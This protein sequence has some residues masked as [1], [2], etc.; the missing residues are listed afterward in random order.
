MSYVLHNETFARF[1]LNRGEF[2]MGSSKDRLTETFSRMLAT[3]PFQQI[4]IEDVARE[5]GVSRSTFYRHFSDKFELMNWVFKGRVDALA[6]NNPHVSDCKHFFI[7]YSRFLYQNKDYF[8]N[9]IKYKGQ[10][11]LKDL[12][13]TDGIKLYSN[14]IATALAGNEMPKQV[15]F[16]IEVFVSGSIHITMQWLEN[17]LKETP[18]ELAE[19]TFNCMP[20]PMKKY[21]V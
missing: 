20:E 1:C 7:Q 3:T 19:L 17:G 4:T 15:R 16:A 12:L 14:Y 8:Q 11:S 2:A 18:E 13:Y 5:A 21:F 9:A 6:A 10:N